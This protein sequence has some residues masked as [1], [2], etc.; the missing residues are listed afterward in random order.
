MMCPEVL[1]GLAEGLKQTNMIPGKDYDIV[2]FS[3]DPGD[4]AADAT[5]EKANFLRTLDLPGAAEAVHF[6]T[7]SPANIEAISASTGFQ[8]VRVPGPD[9][10]SDQFAHSSVI[11]F[12]TPDGRLSKYIRNR[13]LTS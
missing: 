12:A 7:G 8:Y 3:I 4:S 9:G 13:V 6:L 5:K 2:T 11:M 1:H 10:K